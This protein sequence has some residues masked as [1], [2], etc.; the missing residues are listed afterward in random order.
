[1][2]CDVCVCIYVLNTCRR[3]C[4]LVGYRKSQNWP[5]SEANTVEPITRILE[6]GTQHPSSSLQYLK[7]LQTT[8]MTTTTTQP[9]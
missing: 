2:M 7:I 3:R 6:K 9:Q 8:V 4:S 5:P 1:M